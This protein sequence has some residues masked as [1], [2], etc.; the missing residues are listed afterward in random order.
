[1]ARSATRTPVQARWDPVTAKTYVTCNTATSEISFAISAGPTSPTSTSTQYP[2]SDLKV[3]VPTRN[4]GV[5]K[6]NT[7]ASSGCILYKYSSTDGRLYLETGG[8]MVDS[9]SGVTEQVY[10]EVKVKRVP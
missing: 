7:L 1:M 9:A 8:R 2:I 6:M 4:G 10:L 3:R 5:Q